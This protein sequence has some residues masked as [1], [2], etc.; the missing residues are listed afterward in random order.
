MK[1]T[2][3]QLLSALALLASLSPTQA[4]NMGVAF[5]NS[6]DGYIEVPY[7]AQIVPKSGITIEAW[8]TYDDS[9]LGTGYRYPTIIRQGISVGG[10]EDF[11]LRVNADNI[12]SKILRWKV[13]TA[14]GSSPTIS[15]TF[16]AGQLNTWTHVAATYDGAT[17]VLYVNGASVGSATGSGAIRDSNNEV[18]R[19]GKGSDVA[20]PIE[21]WNGQIDEV[22]LWPFART[23]AEIQ[24]TMNEE[25]LAVPGLVSTWNL[26]G[27]L[28]DSSSTMHGTVGG[29]LT[30]A[31]TA[32]VLTTPA[33][34]GLASGVST[35]GCLG[36]LSLAPTSTPSA[37]NL[38]FAAVCTRTPPNAL[39]G[40]GIA[41]GVIPASFPLLGVDVFLDTAG[42]QV[43]T[44]T[45]NSLG[46]ARLGMPIGAAF[47]PGFAWAVQSM[48]LDPCGPQGYTASN[49]LSLSVLP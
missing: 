15:W 25:L 13:V 46:A 8:I 24:A 11:F 2:R 4:Q 6:V 37:L 48:V 35:P 30:P 10:S 29:L 31:T 33:F 42:M 21:V 49:A 32:P 3:T 47:P 9:T 45:A 12:N 5:D 1:P 19:I 28:L 14:T 20:T 34:A 26:N 16:A 44:V 38:A 27:N 18:F 7:S 41:F 23:Q 43:T 40:W 39:V 36:A 22:R 17:A